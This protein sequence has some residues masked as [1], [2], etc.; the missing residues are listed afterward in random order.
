[1]TSGPASLGTLRELTNT[2]S[3]V[4]RQISLKQEGP[5][6]WN[7]GA[8]P[9]PAFDP[10]VLQELA[11]EVVEMGLIYSVTQLSTTINQ[12]IGVNPTRPDG[13]M[14]ELDRDNRLTFSKVMA[15]DALEHLRQTRQW[16]DAAV[17]FNLLAKVLPQKP[18]V[19]AK[20]LLDEI[21]KSTYKLVQSLDRAMKDS[22]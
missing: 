5:R 4:V 21:A 8:Q 7:R 19:S 6:K 15:P 22:R 9:L 16:K 14:M 12:P 17:E 13:A 20:L 2:A 18:G 11:L 10:V 3:D 1:M